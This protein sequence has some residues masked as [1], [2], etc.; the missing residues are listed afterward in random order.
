MVREIQTIFIANRAPV[1]SKMIVQE[2]NTAWIGCIELE[3]R[4]FQK[5]L[6]T[7]QDRTCTS[8]IFDVSMAVNTLTKGT[9]LVL[10]SSFPFNRASNLVLQ[11]TVS[12]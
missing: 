9:H 11:I 6:R 2:E 4:H 12:I 1:I 10:V 7:T 3:C 5:V 8:H